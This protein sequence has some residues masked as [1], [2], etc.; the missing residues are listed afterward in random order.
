VGRIDRFEDIEAWQK[1]REVTNQI[2]SIAT[3]NSFE[4]D[5]ALLNQ[6]QRATYS[7]MLNIAEGYGR[8]TDGEF[9]QY[10]IQSRGSAREVQSILYIAQDADYLS[11]EEFDDL[12][13]QLD[14]IAKMLSGLIK[15][16]K[17]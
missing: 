16:L 8:E 7:I 14:E 15:Y 12:Y 3:K 9:K 6:L 11:A 10:L 1:A 13:G 5:Y 2:R 17:N 4:N